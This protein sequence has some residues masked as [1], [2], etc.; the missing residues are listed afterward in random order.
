[1]NIFHL[2]IIPMAVY[3]YLHVYGC[4]LS[5]LLSALEDWMPTVLQSYVNFQINFLNLGL[6]PGYPKPLLIAI[7]CP[8]RFCFTG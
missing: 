2:N 4:N 8:A 5:I 7:I 6:V 3:Q 1:M